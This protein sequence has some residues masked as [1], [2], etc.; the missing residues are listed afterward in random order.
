M[1]TK[2]QFEEVHFV[3]QPTGNQALSDVAGGI[4]SQANRL[5][6]LDPRGWAFL[7]GDDGGSR[8]DIRRLF[9]IGSD[10]LP[11][12]NAASCVI[13]AASTYQRRYA[14]QAARDVLT[15][16]LVASQVVEEEERA[17]VRLRLAEAE[18]ALKEKVRNAY[19]HY[20][21]L[22][23]KGKQLDTSFGRVQNQKPTALNGNDVW[24]ALVAANRAVGEYE[25]SPK[26]AASELRCQRFSSRC[27]W[28]ALID[29]LH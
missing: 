28:I 11:M 1:A 9:G 24:G 18:V 22:T 29:I 13:A 2:G 23:R 27:C 26:N 21:Y 17:D 10:P 25:T 20:V 5:V 4:D 19:R 6:V 7:N 12:D 3:N 14:I 16:R 15:W 8:S